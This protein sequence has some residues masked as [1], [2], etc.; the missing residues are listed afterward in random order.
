MMNFISHKRLIPVIDSVFSLQQ[1]RDAF[2]RLGN[3]EQFGKIV[4]S[5]GEHK[6]SN[7][8]IARL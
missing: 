1:Y 3:G 5:L 2:E 4:L 8:M 7:Q 6:E